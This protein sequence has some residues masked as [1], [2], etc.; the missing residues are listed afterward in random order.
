MVSQI[1]KTAGD[2]ADEFGQ[3]L[4]STTTVFKNAADEGEVVAGKAAQAVKQTLGTKIKQGFEK[5]GE[6]VGKDAAEG[7][8]AEPEGGEGVGALIGAATFIAGLLKG[9]H[10][11]HH[12]PGGQIMNF[13]MQAGS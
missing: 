3:G 5:L 4:K 9:R 13:A 11:A 2:A 1:T 8:E 12:V 10:K 6:D 7:G